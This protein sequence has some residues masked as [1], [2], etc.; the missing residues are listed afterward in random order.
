MHSS[1]SIGIIGDLVAFPTVSRDP[2]R[3]L[4]E[5]V[6]RH[7]DRHGVASEILWN[8]DR[9]KGN[10]WAT[11]GPRDV[12]GVILSGHSDVV[13]VDG[14]AWS[15]DP[16]VMRREG[17]R[18]YGRGTADMK[19][20]IGTVLAAVPDL[21][22]RDLAAPIHIAVSYDEEVGC[23]GVASLVERLAGL[24]VRPGLCI[25]GEPTQ[26]AVKTGHKCAGMYT[27]T[28]TGLSAH[29][30]RAPTAVNA[31]A[32]AA[33]LIAFIEDLARDAAQ[34]GPTDPA[35]EIPQATLSVN[36]IRGGTALNIVPAE[37]VFQLDIRAL[38][39]D[40]LAGLMNRIHAFVDTGLVPR[41]RAIDPAC[42]IEIEEVVHVRGLATDPNHPAVGFVS[43]LLPQAPLGKVDFGTE[44]GAFSL[45]AGI[46]SLV[47]GPGSMAQGHTPDEYIEVEQIRRS[48]A[49]LGR[50]ADRLEAAPLPW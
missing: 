32:Y 4:L 40:A 34:T 24:A 39:D 29:S 19:G 10:L 11:I 45:G 27:I 44:A 21:A 12:P 26:M 35:Y 30:A 31:I 7:L 42:G 23:T 1:D 48:E 18:L 17:D 9:T 8:E 20:F 41:M 50:L 37:C 3:S 15:G 13:P 16:F 22:A 46:V 49:M 43:S 36:T 25:V 28:V 14:Q 47:C 2:N 33:R 6:T 38:T 5:Y